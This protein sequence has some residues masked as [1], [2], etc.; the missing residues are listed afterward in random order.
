[1]IHEAAFSGPSDMQ[2]MCA[3]CIELRQRGLGAEH[4]GDLNWAAYMH[5]QMNPQRDTRLWWRGGALAAWATWNKYGLT[6][7]LKHDEPAKL[8]LLQRMLAWAKALALSNP[9]GGGVPTEFVANSFASNVPQLRLLA[10]LGFRPSPDG[11]LLVN[12]RS[13]A[14]PLDDGPLPAGVV[15]RPPQ[16]EAELDRR[17]RLHADVWK[18]SKV[19]PEG[20]RITRGAPGYHANMDLVAVMPDGSLGA[21]CICWPE[22]ATLSC[23]FEPVGTH[24]AHRRQGLASALMFAAMRRARRMGLQTALVYCEAKNLPF[25]QS[26]G[27]H[28]LDRALAYVKAFDAV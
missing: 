17:A 25:Y 28:P 26:L 16:G 10:E 24:P 23:E 5:A 14:D 19:T 12:A 21:Y 7:A 9:T 11:A 4:T 18:P 6:F 20:Y 2:A 8:P 13:I 15:I 22:P 1:M 27:F 3:L